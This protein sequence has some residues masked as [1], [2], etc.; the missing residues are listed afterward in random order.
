M[1]VLSW[2]SGAASKAR[3]RLNRYADECFPHAAAPGALSAEQR[4][5][6]LSAFVASIEG[7]IARLHAFA[8]ALGTTLPVPDGDRGKVDIVSQ[9]LDRFCKSQLSGLAEIEP[10]L[11]MDWRARQPQ[12]L[13]RQIQTLVLDLGAYCGAVGI[14]CAP[15]YQWVLDERRYTPVT[16]METSGRVVI[17]HDPAVVA[18]AIHNPVDACAIAGFALSQIVHYRKAKNLWRPNYFCFLADL[19][20]GRYA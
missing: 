20:D 10:A 7:R 1:A 6:N 18:H 4:R 13:E 2:L 5:A 15:Q 8:A 14:R 9:A 11:A 12:G 17:G 16:I 19:A 3:Q